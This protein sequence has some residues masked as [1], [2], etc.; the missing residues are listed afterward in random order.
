MQA[1]IE[2]MLFGTVAALLAV[3]TLVLF[4]SLIFPN[5]TTVAPANPLQ[6][7]GRVDCPG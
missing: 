1:R 7:Q 3:L 5:V 2:T 4:A 6:L